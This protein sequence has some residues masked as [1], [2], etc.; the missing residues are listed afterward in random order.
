MKIS[1]NNLLL[2]IIFLLAS[3]IVYEKVTAK[4]RITSGPS[5]AGDESKVRT[6]DIPETLA[7]AGEA[8]PLN[9]IEVRERLDRELHVNAYWHSSTI[10]SIKRGARWLPQIAEVLKENELPEDYKYLAVIES[11]LMNV[12]SPRGATGFWQIMEA[13]GKELGLEINEEVD[14]RYDPLKSTE[15]ASDYLR[16]AYR[17]FGSYT[18]AAAS[19][20]MGIVG[21]QVRM[22]EQEVGSYYDLLL[23]PETSRYIFRALALKE[24]MENPEKYGYEIPEEHLY[25][26]TPVEYVQVDS[27]LE[28]LVDFATKHDINYKILK[29]YNPWLRKN[30][31]TIKEPGKVYTIKIPENPPAYQ[32][33]TGDSLKATEAPPKWVSDEE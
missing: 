7:F 9:D 11:G 4:E 2:L 10:S 26:A 14:E 21:L 12:K 25:H 19:Y 22:N 29:Q 28:D 5:D 24:I 3:Y 6:F 32:H 27:T 15:A 13:T 33:E 8:V 18:D 31:L 1:R 20:N 30:T 17:H 16:R 23:N